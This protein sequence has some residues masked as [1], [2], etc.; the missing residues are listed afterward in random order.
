MKWKIQ[1][2]DNMSNL[3]NTKEKVNK[4]NNGEKAKSLWNFSKYYASPTTSLIIQE[5]HIT[6]NEN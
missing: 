6:W 2:E 3:V 4:Y 1:P 5:Y